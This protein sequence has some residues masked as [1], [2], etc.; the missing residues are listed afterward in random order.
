MDEQRIAAWIGKSV[1]IKG[2]ITSSQDLTIDG[3][4]EG[5]IDLHEH[6]L[7]V[8]VGGG[9]TGE[10]RA[11]LVTIRGAVIGNI[12]ATSKIEI[13]ETGSVNGDV[14]APSF[15]ML[16]GGVLCGKVAIEGVTV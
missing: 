9:I 12:T 6:H 10:V 3:Q 15:A 7:I 5:R 2:D 11:R 16:D 13:L 4:V 14:T 8:G 1:I